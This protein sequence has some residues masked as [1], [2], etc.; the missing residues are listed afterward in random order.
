MRLKLGR[1]LGI[2]IFLH[3]SFFLAPA[4]LI[5]AWRSEGLPW[6][7]VVVMLGLLLAVFTCVLIHEYGHALMARHFGVQTKD[8]IITPIGGLARLTRMPRR[9]LEELMI[10]IAGPAVNLVIAFLL[11]IYLLATGGN[12]VPS[13][14]Y[15]GLTE[16]STMMMWMNMFLFLFNLIP[17]FPMDGGRILRSSLAFFIPHREATLVAGILGQICAVC[18][19]IYG[20][21]GGQYSLIFIGLFVYFAARYEMTVSKQIA[22]YEQY[23]SDILQQTGVTDSVLEQAELGRTE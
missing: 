3:W 13:R 6:S 4:Y 14:G 9:P 15:A 1:I 2:D 22:M 19:A 12:L 11:G 23:R 17:A 10:T 5:L 21:W 18:F 16:F 7:M 8:I 20:F